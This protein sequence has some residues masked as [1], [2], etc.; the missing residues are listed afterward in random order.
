V[1]LAERSC[2]HL[3]HRGIERLSGEKMPRGKYVGPEVESERLLG[4]EDPEAGEPCEHHHND[5]GSPH[6]TGATGSLGLHALR[7][8]G[9]AISLRT[10]CASQSWPGRS[11][12]VPA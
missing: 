5:A 1:V 3:W 10:E 7:V 12:G 11:I 2:G 6:Q 9:R 8:Y 4:E